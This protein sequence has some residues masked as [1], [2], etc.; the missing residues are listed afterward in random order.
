VTAQGHSLQQRLNAIETELSRGTLPHVFL[1]RLLILKS[2]IMSKSN[3]KKLL[4]E[5][6][7]NLKEI[8][9]CL[10]EIE[11]RVIRLKNLGLEFKISRDSLS[12]T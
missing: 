5:T 4:A 11:N 8:N 10:S 9:E 7:E 2:N 1:I 12:Q 3:A 6:S